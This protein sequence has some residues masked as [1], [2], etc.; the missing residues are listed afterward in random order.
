MSKA[1][2]RIR[3]VE[4]STF[5]MSPVAVLQVDGRGDKS[6][7]FG[8]KSKGLNMVNSFDKSNVPATCRTRVSSLF[9]RVERLLGLIFMFTALAYR[10]TLLWRND[11]SAVC[12]LVYKGWSHSRQQFVKIF[13]CHPAEVSLCILIIGTYLYRKMRISTEV[14]SST[15]PRPHPARSGV[16]TFS[17]PAKRL[18][19]LPPQC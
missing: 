3:Q 1:T 8:D 5:D 9:L 6:T 12:V 16:S 13:R 17:T 14:R 11:T 19:L 7:V 4:W 10:K 18:Q 2:C 15:Y